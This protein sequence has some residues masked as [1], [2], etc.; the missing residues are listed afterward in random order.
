MSHRSFWHWSGY[1]LAEFKGLKERLESHLAQVSQKLARPGVE[2]VNLG[3][4][5][6]PLKALEAGHR[7]RRE[8]VD[9]IFIHVTTYAL[10]ATVLPVVKR[11]KVPVVV[12][13][14]APEPAMNYAK[15]NALKDRT[16]M[17]GE[18]L[19]NCSACAVPEIANVFKRAGISFQQITGILH[20]DPVCWNEVDAWIEAARVANVMFHNRLGLM[21]HYYGGMLD[22]YSDITQHCATFGGHVE[23]IEVDELAA[24]R[25]QVTAV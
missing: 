12:L 17:T 4:I 3:L 22:I 16:V 15:F 20:D 11:A 14:L 7:F 8:D 24:L 25:R 13:N 21:G 19:A 6:S 9:L 2:I 5:D 10:S 1:I 23:F 18:W